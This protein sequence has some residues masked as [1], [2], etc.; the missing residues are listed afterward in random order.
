MSL[1]ALDRNL[2]S[3]TMAEFFKTFQP[4]MEQVPKD[5]VL[6]KKGNVPQM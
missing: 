5:V 4:G 1:A 6:V 2:M 3:H